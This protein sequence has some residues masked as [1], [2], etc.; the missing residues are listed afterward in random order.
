MNGLETMGK[1]V[2]AYCNVGDALEEDQQVGI[3]LGEA[4]KVGEE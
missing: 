1:N 4:W 3:A 2:G